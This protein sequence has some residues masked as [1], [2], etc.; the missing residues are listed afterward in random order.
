MLIQG[1]IYHEL[2][3]SIKAPKKPINPFL[4]TAPMPIKAKLIKGNSHNIRAFEV[5][6]GQVVMDKYSS[7]GGTKV[8]LTKYSVEFA[9]LSEVS[10]HST[11]HI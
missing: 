1:L 9:L 8:I 10:L 4:N 5:V 11:S 6:V 2:T 7:G 3:I